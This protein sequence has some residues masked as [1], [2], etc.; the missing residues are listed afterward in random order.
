MIGGKSI[1]ALHVSGGAPAFFF[2]LAVGPLFIGG[3]SVFA[4][5]DGGKAPAFFFDLEMSRCL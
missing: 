3:R 5:H 2:D 1:F 4:L